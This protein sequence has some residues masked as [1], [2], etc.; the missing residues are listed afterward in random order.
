MV[1][2]EYSKRNDNGQWDERKTGSHNHAPFEVSDRSRRYTAVLK[3]LETAASDF[4]GMY[5]VEVR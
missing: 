5:C 4:D 3:T 2:L 1:T